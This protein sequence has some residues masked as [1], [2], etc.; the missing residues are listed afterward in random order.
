MG[1]KSYVSIRSYITNDQLETFL[2]KNGKF[3][4]VSEFVDY[5][6]KASNKKGVNT[7]KDLMWIR[8]IRRNVWPG[9]K[10][11]KFYPYY[12]KDISFESGLQLFQMPIGSPNIECDTLNIAKAVFENEEKNIDLW[13][14]FR[15]ITKDYSY[16]DISIYIEDV[17]HIGISVDI[18]CR[19][20]SRTL[21]ENTKIVKDFMKEHGVTKIIPHQVATLVGK[22]LKKI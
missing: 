22:A 16:E 19:T 2:K 20:E 8:E 4:G 9:V 11:G 18:V 13:F 15:R 21:K 17:E 3:N 12:K 10:I 14:S 7:D 6:L 1:L 5:V